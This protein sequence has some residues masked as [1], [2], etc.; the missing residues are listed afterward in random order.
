[1]GKLELFQGSPD[2]KQCWVHGVLR[3]L[4]IQVPL[5]LTEEQRMK[6]EAH[7]C[8]LPRAGVGCEGGLV[9]VVLPIKAAGLVAVV[10][11]SGE[12]FCGRLGRGFVGKGFHGSP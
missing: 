4:D 6:L 10:A 11:R 12:A 3:L 9:I 5:G 8:I 1:M 7:N 2:M